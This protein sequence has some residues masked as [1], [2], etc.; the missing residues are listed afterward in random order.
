M[1][2]L[3]AWYVVAWSREVGRSL[4]KRTLLEEKVVLYRTRCGQVVALE[5]ACCHRKLPLSMGVLIEDRIQCGYHGLEFDCSGA[6]VKIPIQDK[7]PPKAKVRSFPVAEKWGLIWLWMGD[8][9]AADTSKI[10]NVEHYEDSSWGVN[11]GPMMTIDCDYRYMADN[12]LDP[13]HVSYVHKTSLGNKDCVGV[14]LDV[15]V[16]DAKVVCSRWIMDCVLAPFFQPYVQFEGKADRLQ[17]YEVQIPSHAII[18]D[19]IAP[20][21]SGAPLG[22]LHEKAFLLDSYNFITP[23]NKDQC[24]YFWFQVRNFKSR[25]KETDELL[26]MDFQAAFD[27]DLIVLSA[28]HIGMKE[29]KVAHL[30]IA[31][32]MGSLRYRRLLSK[33]IDLE[34]ATS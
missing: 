24:M 25:C 31:S 28:V 6:C 2:L 20:A 19:I 9:A 23:I 11:R 3:N 15:E 14:P 17:H 32:D 5:D 8:P 12:L 10:I 7:I 29:A 22:Q 34:N 4:V 30:D 26:T 33:A 13:E 27:E 18:K 16:G 1:Y 21:G